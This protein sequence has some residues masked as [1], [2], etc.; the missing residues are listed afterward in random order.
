MS[1]NDIDLL[2]HGASNSIYVG[3]ISGQDAYCIPQL[4]MQDGP[5]G[6]RCQGDVMKPG[7]ST[8]FPCG[9]A[10]GSTFDKDVAE[11]WGKDM[12]KEFREKGAHIQLGPAL[13]V[14][15]VPVCGRNFE[16][17]S[18]EEPFLGAILVGP[19]VKGI[20]SNSIMANLK[21]YINNNQED[22]RTTVSANLDETLQMDLYIPPFEYGVQ[23]GA[24]SIMCSYNK[25]NN[26]Y[27]CENE[28]TLTS[29]LRGVLGYQYWVMSDWGATHSTAF[30]ANA[31]LDQ[32]MPDD[33]FFG[34][35]LVDAVNN[36]EVPES[37][38]REMAFRILQPMFLIGMFDNAP[39]GDYAAD[40]TSAAHDADTREF[41]A[42]STI[43][44][45]NDDGLLPLEVGKV[46][47]VA[48]FGSAADFFLTTGGGGSG[49][50]VPRYQ[51]SPLKGLAQALN[52][53]LPAR[54][55]C[56]VVG[57]YDFVTPPELSQSL[58]TPDVD[59]CEEACYQKWSCAAYTFI[60]PSSAGAYGTC[61]LHR[62]ATGQTPN[63]GYTS[64]TCPPQ[65]QGDKVQ[66]HLYDGSNLDDAAAL[67]SS[68]D[69]VVAVMATTSS[70]GADRANLELPSDQVDLANAVAAANPNSISLS[71]TPGVVYMPFA[72]SFAA[73]VLMVM[74]GQ[75]EGNAFADVI[76]NAIPPWGR[77]PFTI[78]YKD[79]AQPF[80]PEQY[81]GVNLQTEYTE[82]MEVGYRYYNAS[83]VPV[84][85]PFG[86]GVTYTSFLYED[87][88]VH[89]MLQPN[90]TVTF[91]LYNAGPRAGVE[92]PQLY[93][94]TPGGSPTHIMSQLRAFE[95]TSLGIGESQQVTFALPDR[96]L[97]V[98]DTYSRGYRLYNGEYEIFV[99]S[100]VNDIRLST[101]LRAT[102]DGI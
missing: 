31:G 62:N 97:S 40:V 11:R 15:R 82:G 16:Y 19:I 79:Q 65:P 81:P 13:N 75:E 33:S 57:G 98:W 26:T 41:A 101:F 56:T 86:H 2:V 66:F 24:L 45:S 96:A 55:N 44:L 58:G 77:L 67:A 14:A 92:T 27:A 36:G 63:D 85:Y 1:V 78:P 9:L 3:E 5:Q 32:Q 35:A 37:H 49:S 12:G 42:K 72:D 90:R 21:H 28:E 25:V 73:N 47:S 99:G 68:V 23:A 39:T 18:G 60:P 46:A 74:P 34:S 38:F 17:I 30:A 88:T 84:R 6:F 80:T 71:I 43:V 4:N 50:V 51:V 70:E 83:N 8:Q 76:V 22:D 89:D 102:L 53:D 91:T 94:R 69:V 20:Q 87:L 100:S 61:W 54:P 52:A 48:F 29:T 93:M 10:I 64:G 95:K 59:T 7:S